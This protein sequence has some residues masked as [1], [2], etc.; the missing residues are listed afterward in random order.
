MCKQKSQLQKAYPT[1]RTA[2]LP[3][4]R[5][6]GLEPPRVKAPGPSSAGTGPG[7]AI[8]A[9]RA[10][11]LALLRPASSFSEA[12]VRPRVS[13]PVAWGLA[14]PPPW[15][16]GEGAAR[17]GQSRAQEACRP[18]GGGIRSGPPSESPSGGRR[19]HLEAGPRG[20][21]Q[22][23][24]PSPRSRRCPRRHRRWGILP[25]APPSAWIWLDAPPMLGGRGSSTSPLSLR[26]PWRT[27]AF[28]RTSAAC[29]D[30]PRP[31]SQGASRTGHQYV[32][33]RIKEGLKKN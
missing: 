14:W 13:G 33:A 17:P 15:A 32:P 8:P 24:T 22:D 10:S 27:S 25:Q 16:R 2:R 12:A 23:V 29:H 4:P 21:G 26:S 19:C 9:W 18:E 6:V 31:P 1:G 7:A 30:R 11:G 28:R 20:Y 3:A 5:P